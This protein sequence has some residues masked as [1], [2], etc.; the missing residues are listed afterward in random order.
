VIRAVLFDV[1]GTLLELAE[2]VGETYAR[3]ARREGM[4]ADADALGA[5]FRAAFAAARPLAFPGV[6]AAERRAHE[7]DWWRSIVFAAFAAA[8]VEGPPSSLERAFEAVFEH[9][10]RP[11][12][13][14]VFDDVRPALASLRAAGLRLGVVSNFDGRLHAL[15]DRL[16]LASAFDAIVLSSECGFAKP[17]IRIFAEALNRIG[18]EPAGALHVGDSDELDIRPARKVGLTALRIDRRGESGVGAIGDLREL[19]SRVGI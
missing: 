13:W 7:R 18:T 10:S 5:A 19:A 16:A 6:E 11:E 9:F 14:R 12:A 2:P 3:F 4:T 1:A 17:D 15:L 8:R